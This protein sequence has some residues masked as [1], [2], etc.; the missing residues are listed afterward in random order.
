M[1]TLLNSVNKDFI[2]SKYSFLRSAER[3]ML[4]YLFLLIYGSNETKR[5]MVCIA[6]NSIL[7]GLPDAGESLLRI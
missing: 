5:D 1:K 7:I 3:G 2:R 6:T 4:G